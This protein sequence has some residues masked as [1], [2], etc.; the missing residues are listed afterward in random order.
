MLH[1]NLRKT[2]EVWR[3]PCSMDGHRDGRYKAAP[4]EG[5]WSAGPWLR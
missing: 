1:R 4:R 3:R 2:G 5:A